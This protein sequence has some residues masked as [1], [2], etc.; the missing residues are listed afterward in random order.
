MKVEI[1][2]GVFILIGMDRKVIVERVVEFIDSEFIDV[3][4]KRF[5]LF[6]LREGWERYLRCFERKV[7][8]E[9]WEEKFV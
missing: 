5:I 3:R 1:R 7:F 4:G 6:K 2:K 9:R 8:V